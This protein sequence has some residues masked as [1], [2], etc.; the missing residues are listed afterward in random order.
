MF[1]K[2]I[3]VSFL[4]VIMV[5]LLLV[6]QTKEIK[7]IWATLTDTAQLTPLTPYYLEVE[8]DE[9]IE[10]MI[11]IPNFGMYK[12]NYFITGASTNKPISSSTSD[13]KF[14]ISVRQRMFNRIMPFN[15]QLMLT[16]TQKSFWALYD[17]SSPF[18]DNNYNPGLLISRY[19][20]HNNNLKGVISL[21]IEHESNGKDGRE[22][23]S[24]NYF[25]L[26]GV[27]FFN[28][29]FYSQIK[30]W[31][32]WLDE[33][34]H[35]LLDYRGYGMLALNYRSKNDR[36]ATSLIINPIKNFSMN[37]QL[38]VSYK[39]SKKTNQF[40]FIQWYNG[41]SEGLLDYNMYGSMVRG[42]ICIKQPFRGVY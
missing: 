16:Y 28:A 32:G 37:T 22:N 35:D 12:D 24:W 11:A 20:I 30:M 40:L 5:N 17:E 23:R 41:Y 8:P 7:K 39:L 26:S 29:Y 9:V 3:T 31:Y 18:S 42:G 10:Q 13:A 19:V 2:R 33:D 4:L 15:T 25:T 27:H 38:E 36:I 14:Q 34:N 21:S 1:I 6:S